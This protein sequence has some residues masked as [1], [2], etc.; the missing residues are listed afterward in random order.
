MREMLERR[1]TMVWIV[2]GGLALRVGAFLA[3]RP[4]FAFDKTGI[5]H[6]SIAYDAYARNLLSTGVYGLSAGV[7]DAALPPLYGALVA[8]VY[9]ITGRGALPIVLLNALAGVV[10]LLAIRRIGSRLFTLGAAVG[11]LA[12]ACTAFYPYLVFQDLTLIDTSLF[13]A[14]LYLFLAAAIELRDDGD[15]RAL[16]TRSLGCGALLGLATLARPITPPIA[17]AVAVWLAAAVGVRRAAVRLLPAAVA[18]A[19]V[20]GPWA[21]RNTRVFGTPV[22]VTTNGGS[23]FW[24]GNNPQTLSYL[25]AGYDPQWTSP[26]VVVTAADR[27]GPAADAE[28]FRSAVAYLRAHAAAIPALVWTKLRVQWSIDVSPRRNPTADGPPAP[29]FGA[30]TV[31]HDAGRAMRLGGLPPAEP[32]L[33]YSQPLFD[34]VG[35]SV[36][37]IYWGALFLLGVAGVIATRAQWRSVSLLWLLELA[38][39]GVYVATHPSTRYRAPGDPAWFLFAAAA[40]LAL[41]AWPSRRTARRDAAAERGPSACWIGT[42]R[43]S[44]PLDDT[45]SAKWRALAAVCPLPH[46]I[47][48]S[49]GWRP[50]RFTQ[51]ATFHL[52]PDLPWAPARRAMMAAAG[53]VLLAW[54][55]VGRGVRVVVA[56]SPLEGA[57]AAG[58]KLVL[59]RLGVPIVLVIE[60]H[61]DFE[62]SVVLYRRVRARRLTRAIE[63]RLA[64]FALRHA[65]AGRAVSAATRRQ[66][67]HWAPDLPIETFPAWIDV[68]TFSA[69]ERSAPPS[70]SPLV[71][72]AGVLAPIKGVDVLVEAFATVAPR[73]P[74]AR[75]VIVGAAS[76]RRYAAALGKRIAA[77][78]LGPRVEI[79]GPLDTRA[80][81]ALMARARVLAAPSRSEGLSRVALEAM[82]VGTPVVASAVGGLPEI[83]RDGETGWLVPP[84]DAARLAAALVRAFEDGTVDARGDRARRTAA[85]IL[86][87][88]VFTAGHG[89]LLM[90]TG[91]RREAK[92]SAS[93]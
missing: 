39:T 18:A 76:N 87:P 8:A 38:I 63:R 77:L 69:I 42:G 33:V 2:L 85:A 22:G 73:I 83:V 46:V 28:Y 74:E 1:R 68:E 21:V 49:N 80:L 60:S 81:A 34:R 64:A 15:P 91:G 89:R 65:D 11:T 79:A 36:H 70:A 6:G 40:M 24:Q 71:L 20:V 14:L 13:M 88:D 62:A 55:A 72:F 84:G 27:L 12:A 50:R 67:Q 51:I 5:V 92:P 52:L 93:S 17:A 90:A 3:F 45:T 56:Q 61:G 47:G 7:P 53:P 44:R 82:L 41:G 58:V 78:G 29:T 25:R 9:R 54:L 10:A 32:V 23:N 37:R 75:L 86:A 48:F 26:P 30:V 59:R 57:V 31:D 16:W 66:L 19:L 43:Y 4:L 35:R